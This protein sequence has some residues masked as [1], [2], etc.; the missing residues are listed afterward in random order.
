MTSTTVGELYKDF[1]K[2]EL[3]VLQAGTVRLV[4]DTCKGEEKDG[5]LQIS[6]VFRVV[7]GVATDGE[8]ATG[9]RNMQGKHTLSEK[10]GWIFFPT[11]KGYG[12]GK[13]YFRSEPGAEQIAQDLI[14]RVVDVETEIDPWKGQDRNKVVRSAVKLVG[15]K[16]PT[17]GVISYIDGAEA[18]ATPAPQ[19]TAPAPATPPAPAPAPAP[20]AAPPAPAAPAPA[21]AQAPPLPPQTAQAPPLPPQQATQ[22]AVQPPV[23]PAQ[24]APQA[25]PVQGAPP[26]PQP[27]A[28]PA[29][30]PLP[31]AEAQPAPAPAPA[32]Q[33]VAPAA[34]PQGP[35]T[36]DAPF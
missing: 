30:Q 1:E 12:L 8:D 13:D 31:P 33:P 16:D 34:A 35:P 9:K 7:Q 19:T 11:M 24:P 28:G 29:V 27:Q 23:P 22:P 36:E 4:V 2:D 25:V 5:N 15:H 26:V 6:P 32:Q 17:T 3:V 21:P 18:P 20:Q 14:G 10:S